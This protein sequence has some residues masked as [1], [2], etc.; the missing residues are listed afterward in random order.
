MW[1]RD[2]ESTYFIP[3]NWCHMPV[4]AVQ[5]FNYFKNESLRCAYYFP[6]I[7]LLTTTS[8]INKEAVDTV[9]QCSFVI[10]FPL[11]VLMT[12]MLLITVMARRIYEHIQSLKESSSVHLC[13]QE[14]TTGKLRCGGNHARCNNCFSNYTKFKIV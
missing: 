10:S 4:L 2:R 1:P 8:S 14:G 6:I 11:L 9:P 12:P 7:T 5:D 3:F 13:Y